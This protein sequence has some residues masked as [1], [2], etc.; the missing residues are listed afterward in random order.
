MNRFCIA[1][2]DGS[3]ARFF[4]LTERPADL[5]TSVTALE[6]LEDLVNPQAALRDEEVYSTTKTGTRF[7]TFDRGVHT[8]S[9]DDHRNQNRRR[10]EERFA[11][12]VAEHLGVLARRIEAREV[13]LAA[14]PR[15]MGVLRPEMERLLRTSDTTLREVTKELTV[16]TPP[17]IHEQLVDS[18]VLPAPG[19]RPRIQR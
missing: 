13:V 8:T 9:F 3:R 4:T 14:A 17:R 12:Q 7:S 16:L 5:E 15:M 6:E 2:V 11:K 18:G 1:V 19:P 10:A